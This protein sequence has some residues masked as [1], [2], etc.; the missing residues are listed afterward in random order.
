MGSWYIDSATFTATSWFFPFFNRVVSGLTPWVVMKVLIHRGWLQPQL[1][2]MSG[3]KLLLLTVIF[4]AASALS[5]QLVW[6]W[7]GRPASNIWIDVWPMFISNEVGALLMLNGFK[8]A[9]DRWH[10][11]R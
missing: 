7:L 6:W 5:H 1:Q 4:S 3:Q 10:Q 8:F 2:S 9:L 11:L